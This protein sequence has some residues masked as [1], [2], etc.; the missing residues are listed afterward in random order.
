MRK[1]QMSGE[2][3][4]AANLTQSNEEFNRYMVSIGADWRY[5]GF[6]DTPQQEGETKISTDYETRKTCGQIVGW[7]NG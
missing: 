1:I 7:I 4:A 3:V 2:Q 5:V 6:A